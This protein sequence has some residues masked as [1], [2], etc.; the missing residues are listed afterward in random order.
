[1]L[2]RECPRGK[3]EIECY[4]MSWWSWHVAL[5]H[6]SPRSR[7]AQQLEKHEGVSERPVAE[8]KEESDGEKD[9]SEMVKNFQKIDRLCW[10]RWRTGKMHAWLQHTGQLILIVRY[11]FFSF[12]IPV[13]LES[14]CFSWNYCKILV[15]FLTAKLISPPEFHLEA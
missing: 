7:W 4:C 13:V 5:R 6:N 15:D 3:K 9:Q 1:M 8:L 10:W 2:S 14:N 12:L 11:I